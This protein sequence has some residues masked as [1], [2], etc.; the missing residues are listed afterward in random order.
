MHVASCTARVPVRSAVFLRRE[1]AY[2]RAQGV[3]VTVWALADAAENTTGG[4]W[5]DAGVRVCR[6]PGRWTRSGLA[7]QAWLFLRH[8]LRLV[9]LLIGVAGLVPV[10]PRLAMA[11]LANLHAV[12]FFARDA[13]DRGVTG[14][15][16]CFLN[17]PGVVAVGVSTVTRLPVT[18]AGH[19]RDVFVEGR[20]APWLARRAD[21]LVVCHASAAR[22]LRGRLH[23]GLC[24]KLHVVRH[25]LDVNEAV[26]PLPGGEGHVNGTPLIVAAGRFVPKKGF[27]HFIRACGLLADHGVRFRAVLA[28]DGQIGGQ[29]RALAERMHAA[30]RI[31]W[32]GWQEGDALRRLLREAQVVVVPSV[33][34]ADGDRDGIPNLVLEA[35]AADATVVASALP[36]IREAITD[37]L[38]GL[39]VWPGEAAQLA[40]AVARALNDADLR[41]RLAV[42]GR[43][44]LCDAFDLAANGRQLLDLFTSIHN[45]KSPAQSSARHRGL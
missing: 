5:A 40:D 30:D 14:V 17:L 31:C 1:I 45:G 28:G 26:A 29:L 35:W 33:I 8:P 13:L 36:G 25:G 19:A 3:Q 18:L 43:Q 10:C 37:G 9:R 44:R 23:D 41:H 4:P 32:P 39:L 11:L 7:A 27:E 15:H 24:G 21:G 22:A 20:A 34:A 42:A 16:G 6:R 12:A 38:D 2:L